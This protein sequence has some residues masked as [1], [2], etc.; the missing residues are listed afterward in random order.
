MGFLFKS[1]QISVT[2]VGGRLAIKGLV[3]RS[4]LVRWHPAVNMVRQDY[5]AARRF[6]GYSRLKMQTL[7]R[8]GRCGFVSR[9]PLRKRAFD[10]SPK[11]KTPQHLLRGLRVK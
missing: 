11:N 2:T 3:D 4:Q 5:V 1:I 10:G 9:V 8:Q 7:H 6:P